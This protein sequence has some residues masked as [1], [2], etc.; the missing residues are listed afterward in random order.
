VG[1]E[2]KASWMAAEV[3]SQ[4]CLLLVSEILLEQ[5]HSNY[6][7]PS[8]VLALE[9]YCNYYN[10]RDNILF[11]LVAALGTRDTACR[12]LVLGDKL[13]G[14]SYSTLELLET[15]ANLLAAAG[16]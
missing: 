6:S 3:A 13:H 4:H 15:A 5:F 11:V 16:L 1:E 12:A 8:I 14:R 9:P 2:A 7:D 10:H